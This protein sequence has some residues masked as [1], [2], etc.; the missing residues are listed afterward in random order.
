MVAPLYFDRE[1]AAMLAMEK[2]ILSGGWKPLASPNKKSARKRTN[3][4]ESVGIM[5]AEPLIGT[6][7][8]VFEI[9]VCHNLRSDSIHIS[10]Y[11]EI[12]PRRVLPICRYEIHDSLHTNPLWFPPVVIEGG[13]FHKHVYNERSIREGDQRDWCEC[14]SPLDLGGQCSPDIAMQRLK[15]KFID[16]LHL[17]FDERDDRQ[18]FINFGGT[19]Q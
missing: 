10:L 17:N 5:S 3:E 13:Q 14:A 15:N 7:G 1:I 16:D 9:D 2:R 6:P 18:T 4:F 11:A 12:A 19:G 8:Y